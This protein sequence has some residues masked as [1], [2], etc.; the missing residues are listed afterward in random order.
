MHSNWNV[1]NTIG[2]IHGDIIEAMQTV[3][4]CVW[5]NYFIFMSNWLLTRPCRDKFGICTPF[6]K[7]KLTILFNVTTILVKWFLMRVRIV[8]WK[9]SLKS[10]F[11][12]LCAWHKVFLWEDSWN[13]VQRKRS[14]KRRRIFGVFARMQCHD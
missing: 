7:L 2:S 10:L 13:W 8:M 3:Y 12:Y 11:C 4:I 9:W 5:F 1:H 14:P 6:H